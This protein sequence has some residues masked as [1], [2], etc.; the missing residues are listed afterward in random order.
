MQM[1]IEQVFANARRIPSIAGREFLPGWPQARSGS[2]R[3]SARGRI[4]T[5]TKAWST[6]VRAS[7]GPAFSSYELSPDGRHL[8]LLRATKDDG[9]ADSYVEVVALPATEAVPCPSA[10]PSSSASLWPTSS[11]TPSTVPL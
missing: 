2:P 8:A 6:V 10:R 9:G 7:E 1:P 3:P 5:S 11:A 4:A